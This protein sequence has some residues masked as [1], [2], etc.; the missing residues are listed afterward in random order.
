MKQGQ[1]RFVV[2]R[3][4]S[5]AI[6]WILMAA[7][8][9]LAEGDLQVYLWP[10]P[11]VESETITLEQIAIVKG[12][13]ALASKARVAGLGRFTVIGQ[14][15]VLDRPTIISRLASCGVASD[16][17]TLRGAEKVSVRRNEQNLGGDRLANV[18]LSLLKGLS[19]A[20]SKIVLIRPPNPLAIEAG[21]KAELKPRL[22]APIRGGLARVRVEAIED[23]KVVAQQDVVFGVKYLRHRAVANEDL[24]A[25]VQITSA[26]VT[27]E[28]VEANEP[29]PAGWAAPYG[30]LTR[31]RMSK[32]MEVEPQ[33]LSSVEA[34]V[35]V[36]RRQTVVVKLETGR[37]L[38]SSL[39]EAQA[40]GKVGEFVPVKM[41][42]DK[43]S[44]VIKARIRPDGTL[45]PYHEG[46]QL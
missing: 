4:A 8:A 20:P 14:Q 40:D 6:A 23:G 9:A 15:I 16:S 35:V 12:D 34:P 27:V 3:I 41:G 32:G 45:E 26:N 43:E 13:E 19:P 37:L 11:V 7:A 17:V 28:T 18:A 42:S 30:M 21:R 39:G 38:I 29:E 36:R 31:Q 10:E 44:R 1:I 33:R 46:I 25:G 24:A 22:T 2:V 5:S